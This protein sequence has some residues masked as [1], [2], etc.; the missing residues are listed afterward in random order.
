VEEEEKKKKKEVE[1]EEKKKKKEKK[2]K[3]KKKEKKKKNNN[4]WPSEACLLKVLCPAGNVDQR[5]MLYQ[6]VYVHLTAICVKAWTGSR[7]LMLPESPDNLR[8]KVVQLLALRTGR[9]YPQRRYPLI[10]ISVRG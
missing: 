1:E 2:K 10:L 6:Y 8:M 5:D 4:H 7:R 9:L 3:E